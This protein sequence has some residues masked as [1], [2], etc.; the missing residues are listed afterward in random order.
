MSILYCPASYS[1]A[2]ALPW[3]MV[4]KLSDT[5]LEK[6]DFPMSYQVSVANSFLVRDGLCVYF[7]S[8]P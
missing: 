6:V 1:W 5:P 4:D 3:T 8:Q 7:P 2:W